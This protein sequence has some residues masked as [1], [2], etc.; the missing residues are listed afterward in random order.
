MDSMLGGKTVLV[1]GASRGLGRAVVIECLRAGAQVWAVARDPVVLAEAQVAWAGLGTACHACPLDV[2]NEPAVTSFIASLDRLDILI[3]NAGIARAGPLLQT[4]T[5]ELREV[6][7]TNVVAAFVV[8]RESARKMVEQGGGLIINIASDAAIKGIARMG[9]Y[10]ASKHAI[11]GLG[12]SASLELRRQGVRVLTFCPGPIA[13]DIFGPGTAN[14]KALAP[15]T[16]ARMIV[17][18]ASLPAD[19]EVQELLVQPTEL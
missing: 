7:E 6:L 3:N 16:L 1:T 8:L 11:L 9:P 15:Q 14:P 18:L 13:T 17:H 19:A 4:S 10:V 2:R 5:A 12:R